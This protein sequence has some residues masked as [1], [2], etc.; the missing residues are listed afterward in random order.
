MA[1]KPKFELQVDAAKNLATLRYFGHVTAAD[2]QA[3]AAKIER[4]LPQLRSGF[5]VLTDLS[6]LES[7]DLDCVPSLTKIMDL[8]RAKGVATVVRVVP[9]AAKDIGFN[10]LSIIHLRRGV[11]IITCETLEEARRAL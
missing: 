6:E 5:T 10:I 9:D 11:K 8:L 7:M 1:T 4:V 3:A 2:T